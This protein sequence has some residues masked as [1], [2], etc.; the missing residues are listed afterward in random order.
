MFNIFLTIQVKQVELLPPPLGEGKSYQASFC[1]LRPSLDW[2]AE[3]GWTVPTS[4]VGASFFSFFHG[5][6]IFEKI[7]LAI[8][9][10]DCLI[11]RN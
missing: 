2:S 10:N 3:D 7:V 4:K 5:F 9:A 11:L 1:D 8:C 6:S